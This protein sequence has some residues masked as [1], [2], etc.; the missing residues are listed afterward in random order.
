ML[1]IR[2]QGGDGEYSSYLERPAAISIHPSVHQLIN[3][4]IESYTRPEA[5][6]GCLTSVIQLPG[7]EEPELIFREVETETAEQ[8]CL[9][10]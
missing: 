1:L 10:L 8:R 5:C 6:S 3:P 2:R 4:F 7:L 9:P